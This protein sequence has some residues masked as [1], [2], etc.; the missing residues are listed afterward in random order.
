VDHVSLSREF[1]TDVP[2]R[3][4]RRRLG[5]L[6]ARRTAHLYLVDFDT[7]KEW[8][9]YPGDNLLDLG[10]KRDAIFDPVA[11]Q[12]WIKP[13]G[14]GAFVFTYSNDPDA[15]IARYVVMPASASAYGELQN[16]AEMGE[17]VG[18]PDVAP[19][20]KFMVGIM[21]DSSDVSVLRWTGT[22]FDPTPVDTIEPNGPD[23]GTLNVAISPDSSTVI[24][25]L[26]QP[27]WVIAYPV[28]EAGFGTAYSAPPSP[29]PK[30]SRGITWH[31]S[32]EAVVLAWT[33]STPDPAA[34]TV[35]AWAWSG[36]WGARYADSPEIFT[37]TFAQ[38]T[39]T[40]PKFAPDGETLLV[41]RV[42]PGDSASG[43]FRIYNFTLASGLTTRVAASASPIT[44]TVSFLQ[45]AFNGRLIALGSKTLGVGLVT[46]TFIDGVIGPGVSHPEY[47]DNN[48]LFPLPEDAFTWRPM[49]LCFSRDGKLLL[50]ANG[51]T[52][53]TEIGGI[54]RLFSVADDGTLTQVGE[55]FTDTL[56][57]GWY[58][59]AWREG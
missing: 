8:A 25:G 6:V 31:P 27:P 17:F 45:L 1:S 59:M 52:A 9:Y 51:V 39:A 24:L 13:Y 28:S 4:P 19:N 58:R 23:G 46:Y 5:K 21:G 47:Y 44:S 12:W 36:G 18:V 42:A 32:G 16:S 20:G 22:T 35:A 11:D 33:L 37:S 2:Q 30:A 54:F 29:P 50:G 53:G 34:V 40:Q 48:P 7:G 10:I 49:F 15:E 57:A 43:Q 55:K 14:G 56:D 38:G 41:P 3:Q 26:N